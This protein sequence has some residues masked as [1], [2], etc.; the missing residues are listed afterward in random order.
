MEGAVI[1]HYRLVL[2]LSAS[3]A[4]Q[5]T[6]VAPSIRE[7]L[8]ALLQGFIGDDRALLALYKMTVYGDLL[9]SFNGIDK[10]FPGFSTGYEDRL[11]K[12]VA[13]RLPEPSRGYV[14]AFV[15]KNPDD[16]YELWEPFFKLF[17]M[18][19]VEKVRFRVK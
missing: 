6:G 13:E 9:N 2:D 5:V 11:I 1:K 7:H 14:L 18:L 10:F 12:Y 15:E 19:Q 8:Q 17:S 3:V 16:W 4:P